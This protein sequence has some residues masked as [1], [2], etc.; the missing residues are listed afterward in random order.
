MEP[1]SNLHAFYQSVRQQTLRLTENLSAEDMAVQSMTEASPAKWHL[2]HTSWFFEEFILREHSSGYH[3]FDVSFRY[4]FN[5]YYDAV[6]ERHPRFDRGL[7]TRPALPA[8]LDYR[9]H[10]DAHMKSLMEQRGLC[11]RQENNAQNEALQEMIITG[12]HHEMQHQELLLTDILHLFSF[13]PLHPAVFSTARSL[14]SSARTGALTMCESE[15]G[16][17]EIGAANAGFSYDCERPR[18]RVYLQPFAVANRLVSNGEWLEFMNDGGY[19]N[20]LLWLADGWDACQ[21]KGW[22]APLYWRELEGQWQQ[23]G[24]DGLQ[25]LNFAAPVCHISYYEADAYARWAGKRLPSEQEWEHSVAGLPIEGNFM[26]AA[27]WRPQACEREGRL[28]Q[29]YG[30]VWEW[31][32][33]PYMAYPGFCPQEGALQEYNGKFMANQFVLRGGSCATPRQQMRPSYRNFFFPEQRWQFT[34]LRLAE[35]ANG[36]R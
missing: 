3:P 18:H 13:N 15:G 31:T 27:N 29:V 36:R 22:R 2:A 35:D 25:R 24:L 30:D 34:G 1:G 26:E 10:V 20:P 9:S 23:F 6:G 32:Q 5:S 7:L 14:P 17:V 28:A 19:Q 16:L 8:V 4:L 12:L 21:R 11:D 33:S